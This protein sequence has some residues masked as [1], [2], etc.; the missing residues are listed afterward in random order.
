MLHLK[1]GSDV[2]NELKLET[3]VEGVNRV[4]YN[5]NNPLTTFT[6]FRNA[7]WWSMNL[8]RKRAEAR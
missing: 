3:I 6:L 1:V 5:V 8:T 7:P 2:R 4:A